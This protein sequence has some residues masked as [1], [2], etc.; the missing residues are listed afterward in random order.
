[1][2]EFIANVDVFNG[3]PKTNKTFGK[4]KGTGGNVG[5][6]GGGM[7]GGGMVCKTSTV[8][9]VKAKTATEAMKKVY[10]MFSFHSEVTDLKKV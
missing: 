5:G 10:A 8:V 2:K 9:V 7:G 4:A 6:L 3:I 1:M